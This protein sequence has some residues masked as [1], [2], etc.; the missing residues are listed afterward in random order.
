M[1]PKINSPEHTALRARIWDAHARGLSLGEIASQEKVARSTVQYMIKAMTASGQVAV[2]KPP[3]RK[4]NVSRRYALFQ[5]PDLS[6]LPFMDCSAASCTCRYM[7]SLAR[8]ANKH[9]FW[10]AKRLA[11]TLHAEMVA[12]LTSRPPGARVQLF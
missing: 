4:P 3:G 1:A 8:L 12:A 9:P 7:S 10:G 6:S 2:T 11:D 5:L